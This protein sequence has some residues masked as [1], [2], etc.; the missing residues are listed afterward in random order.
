M[1]LGLG[2]LIVST[3][4][5]LFALNPARNY[6]HWIIA[7]ESIRDSSLPK[8]YTGDHLYFPNQN[9]P[10]KEDSFLWIND[11]ALLQTYKEF[12]HK[13]SIIK[14]EEVIDLQHFV[15]IHDYPKEDYVKRL[16]IGR[17][18]VKRRFSVNKHSKFFADEIRL[19]RNLLE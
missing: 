4:R 3:Q 18:D 11:N 12:S 15:L 14:T 2:A 10:A 16:N 5:Q 7:D 1:L 13:I 8:V 17:A 19:Q 6:Y 9:H